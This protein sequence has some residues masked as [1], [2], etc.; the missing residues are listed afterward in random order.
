MSTTNT[1]SLP[2]AMPVELKLQ[3]F[4]PRCQSSVDM[5]IR[6]ISEFAV[7]DILP[8]NAWHV[9]IDTSPNVPLL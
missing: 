9:A 1:E 6:T 4:C 8:P 2:I 3:V 5:T 7:F